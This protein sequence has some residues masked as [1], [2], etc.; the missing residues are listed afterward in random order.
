MKP[1]QTIYKLLDGTSWKQ[2]LKH[3]LD[4]AKSTLRMT[5]KDFRVIDYLN[6][7]TFDFSRASAVGINLERVNEFHAPGSVS[8]EVR[9]RLEADGPDEKEV[10]DKVLTECED[11]QLQL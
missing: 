8:N 7:G 10:G 5:N 11:I 6:G 2:Y 9:E 4:Q 3:H 1:L